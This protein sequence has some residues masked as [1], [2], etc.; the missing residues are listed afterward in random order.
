MSEEVSSGIKK[1][2]RY[3]SNSLGDMLL[4][5]D[6]EDVLDNQIR[7][8]NES[9]QS[10]IQNVNRIIFD[11]TNS[12][13]NIHDLYER[14]CKRM[15]WQEMKKQKNI[16]SV[17]NKTKELLEN[18]NNISEQDVDE[19]WIN[20]FFKF[21]Q[22]ISNEKMQFLWGKIL[23]GEIKKP[24]TFSLRFLDAMAKVSQEEARMFEKYSIHMIH[25]G[26]RIVIIRD[27]EFDK[28]HN[29]I[30]DD[31]LML[32]ECDLIDASPFLSVNFSNDSRDR[33]IAIIHYKSQCITIETMKDKTISIPVFQLTSLGKELFQIANINYDINYC[34]D[35][36]H[37]L[38]KTNK[39]K[40]VSLYNNYI[41]VG[42]SIIPVGKPEKI[43]SA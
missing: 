14:T 35:I 2:Y 4:P 26:S 39:D 12:V 9:S 34:H 1:L 41:S 42:N 31:I 24:S 8:L 22:D 30:Y 10:N 28:N 17:V 15:I 6:V 40:I 21:V 3:V 27:D 5:Q 33:T 32:Q 20:H 38:A 36:A 7:Q 19:D 43:T 11:D 18:E 16:E 37:Y 25:I 23:A 13:D 29:I